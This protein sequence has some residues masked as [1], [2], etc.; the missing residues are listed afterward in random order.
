M[1]HAEGRF[2]LNGKE[3]FYE[4]NGTVDMALPRIY[5]NRDEMHKNWRN[6]N[7]RECHCEE[8]KYE[9]V[10]LETSYGAENGFTNGDEF[11]FI[12]FIESEVCI[13]CEAIV[14]ELMQE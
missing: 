1:S 13:P 8:K 12:D 5:E 11:E 10:M 2:F 6:D 3:Y 4:Y 7:W 14:G 9:K